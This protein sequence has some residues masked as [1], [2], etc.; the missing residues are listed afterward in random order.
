MTICELGEG[1][2]REREENGAEDCL[3]D[4]ERMSLLV[5]RQSGLNLCRWKKE[6]GK[7]EGCGDR[8]QETRNVSRRGNDALCSLP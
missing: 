5:T 6:G 7:P 8:S 1:V 4:R 3:V 2:S